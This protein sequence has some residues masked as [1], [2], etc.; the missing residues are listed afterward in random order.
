MTAFPT[1]STGTVSIAALATSVVGV[2]SN[3]T[4][5]NAMPGDVLVVAHQPPV[6]VQDVVS[7]LALDIDAWPFAA[8]A[9]VPYVLYKTSPLRFVGG[10]AMADVSTLVAALNTD[11]F[12]VFV[13]PTLTVPDPSYGDENQFAFQPGTG[14][15]WQKI[16]GLWVFVGN[17]RGFGTIS[18]WD[19]A[20][21]FH[22][23]DIATFNGSTYI[24]L[25]DSTGKQPDSNPTNWL[26]FAAKGL[27][28]AVY[29]ASSTSSVAIG[30]GAKA[31]TIVA[32]RGYTV[33]QRVRV[34]ADASN[35]VEGA[36]ASYAG[37]TLTV[38]VDHVSGTGTFAS[39]TVNIAGEVGA[40]GSQ[41]VKGD[42][43]AGYGGTSTSMVAVGIG[44]K[45]F[46]TQ[47]NLG[48]TVGARVRVSSGSAYMEGLVTAYDIVTGSLTVNTDKANGSGTLAAWNINL[49]GDPGSPL[50]QK[51][52]YIF[53]S[54][55]AQSTFSGADSHG[56]VLGYTVGAIELAVN[57]LKMPYDKYTASNGTSIVFSA[58]LNDGDIVDVLA[59]AAF[60][61]ADSLSKSANGSDIVDKPGF[62]KTIGVNAPIIR[63]HLAGLT[64]TVSGASTFNLSAGQAT[65][66]TNSDYIGL[67]VTWGKGTGAFVAGSSNVG[68]LDTGTI[69][70]STWYHVHLIKN[71]TTAA[72]DVLISLSA[73]AP[74]LPAGFT[75]FRRIGSMK[76]DASSHWLPFVQTG[77][78]FDWTTPIQDFNAFTGL[79]ATTLTPFTLSVPTGLSVAAFFG[80]AYSGS[81]TILIESGLVS[82]LPSSFPGL[83]TLSSAG[84]TAFGEFY[85]QTN[86]LGQV[87]VS[88]PSGS[89][90][91]FVTRGWI[92]R[93]G[94][95]E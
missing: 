36:V 88:G 46:A 23:R 43:G 76:T 59:F 38:T 19:I 2:G 42:A 18:A 84:G 34:S 6:I 44:S 79:P 9:A 35:Y 65:D 26:L 48:Y 32:G 4:G 85:V 41:G 89:T 1:Y 25:T 82:Y 15:M 54:T 53:V 40:Q 94:R 83:A 31:F 55:A 10:Q 28:G 14:S 21:A 17:F 95:D 71:P 22:A 63:G 93:R 3:W 75:L 77:D 52:D 49:A 37:T 5:Q 29:V 33:G 90:L 64:M 87:K 39:W 72:V 30:T 60:N 12:F 7:A 58:P 91:Y 56:Q 16:G 11:G 47:A 20:T 61:P 70:A 45:L 27:D 80:A 69:A 62:V 13:G 68:A 67:T 74:T 24:A 57:G 66:S 86:T 51:S 8:V 81:G 92:D 50:G 78:R 73:T